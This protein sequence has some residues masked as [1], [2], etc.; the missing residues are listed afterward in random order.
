[1]SDP[2]NNETP[3]RPTC[4][5][6]NAEQIVRGMGLIFSNTFLYGPNHSV[7]RKAVDDCYT[8]LTKILGECG[9]VLFTFSEEGLLVDGNVIE[10]KNP[11]MRM[12]V[13]QLTALDLSSFSL[14]QGMTKR[15]FEDLIELMNAK[16]E[17]V[18]QLGGFVAIV[19]N[20][21]FE[22]IKVKRV[23]F[24]Q[25][26][27]HE[28]VVD[29]VEVEKA[30]VAAAAAKVANIAEIVAFLGGES[31]SNQE[32]ALKG[33]QSVASDSQKL[34]ELIMQ[35]AEVHKESS[36]IDDTKSF[37]K[38]VVDS[39][40]RAY[41]GLLKDP[42]VKTQKGKK[43]LAKTLLMLEEQMLKKMSEVSGGL[44]DA[45]TKAI[46]DAF[47]EMSDELK[48]DSLTD[49]FIKKKSAAKNSE[50]RILKYLKKRGLANIDEAE[51]KSKLEEAG[52]TMD[53]WTDLLLKSG[54][55]GGGDDGSEGKGGDDIIGVGAAV[56]HLAALLVRMENKFG[57]NRPVDSA[58]NADEFNNTLREVDQE[59]ANIVI[60]TER[61]IE[62]LVETI[63]ADREAGADDGKKEGK[64][65]SMSRAKLME[66]LAEA[67]QELCQPLSVINCS[68]D[69][70]RSNVL[71]SIT[72]QQ[73]EMLDLASS[74]GERVV[75]LVNK[76]MEISGVPKTLQPD[77]AI[78]SSLY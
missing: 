51:L 32:D 68:L 34:A 9:E 41:E 28:E 37:T 40:K 30:A 21:G 74:N 60:K 24:R 10:Q 20:S 3:S 59:V 49:E 39:L 64:Q 15:K 22:N 62:K 53:E 52:L 54:A 2:D 73:K 16:P 70:M 61:K 47:E 8:L 44:N 78:Q 25:V 66:L 11:L 48:I 29:K 42:S 31:Q 69:M 4:S 72:P 77:A 19:N 58:A 45:D 38:L 33:I 6:N 56:G 27:E 5:V 43:N 50:E 76:L 67:V 35:A 18:K 23:T 55:R 46:S 17:E 63:R 26:E 36:A 12:F 57:K 75:M 14:I 65:P 1:M 13:T 7:T 71:G